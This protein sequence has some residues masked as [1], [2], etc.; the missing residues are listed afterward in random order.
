MLPVVAGE[1]YTKKNIL[2]YSVL[3]FPFTILPYFLGFAGIINLITAIGLGFIIF[4]YHTNFLKKLIKK[5]M[6]R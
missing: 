6:I 5:F 2:I 1:N 4:I 3:L